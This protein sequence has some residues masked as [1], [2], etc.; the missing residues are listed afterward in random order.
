MIRIV[1]VA[2]VA[3]VAAALFPGNVLAHASLVRTVPANGERVSPAPAQVLVVFDDPVEVGPANEVVQNGGDS[4]LAGVPRVSGRT[5]VLALRP[6]VPSGTYTVRWSVVSDDGHNEVGVF[7]FG[8]GLGPVAAPSLT[9]AEDVRASVVAARWAFLSWLLLAA[10][11]ALFE[12]FVARR[13]LTTALPRV[14]FVASLLGV[15]VAALVLIQLTGAGLSTRLGLVCLA[16][17]IVGAVSAATVVLSARVARLRSVAL[18]GAIALLPLPT[19]GGHALDAGQSWIEIP[20]DLLHVIPVAFWMGSLVALA[21]IVLAPRYPASERRSSLAR[22]SKLALPSVVLIAVTGVA[23]ALG[24]LTAVSELW[25]TSYGATL[26]AKTTL[27]AALLGLAYYSRSRLSGPIFKLAWPVRSE[28]VVLTLVL[29][30]V[31]VLTTLAPA[32]ATTELPAA[33]QRE[34]KLALDELPAADAVVLGQRDGGYAVAIAV[35]P[36]GEARANFIA[37]DAKAIDVGPVE[38]DGN[39]A[40][41]CGIGCYAG[42]ARA[43]GVVTV[44]RGERTL[45]FDLGRPRPAPMLLAEIS[46]AYPRIRG[47]VYRQR[48]A[49]GLGT[50][51]NALWKEA[52]NGFSYELT[53]GAKAIVIGSARWDRTPSGNWKRSQANGSL[54]IVPP[55]GSSGP[56]RNVQI[57]RRSGSRVVLSFLGADA[58][59]PAWFRVT[60]DARTKQVFRVH[61]TAAAHF[62]DARYVKWDTPIEIGQPPPDGS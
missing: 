52:R 7:S 4:A 45:R 16:A 3:A 37:Q 41:S 39:P 36:T 62:M 47:A 21:L 60:A 49:S 24:E 54:K 17:A 42:A 20:I 26:V 50:Q 38:I 15:G 29:L 12:I 57:L 48:I 19:V 35:R 10:G 46:A 61:M 5:L 14:L 31:G 56:F 55:W 34:G 44:T 11:L 9:A 27:F 23:R 40:R 2:A 25:T 28:A 59:Y 58:T 13:T 30:A 51:V 32:R 18:V 8:F 22:F 6:G 1:V 43:Q 33:S 53:S